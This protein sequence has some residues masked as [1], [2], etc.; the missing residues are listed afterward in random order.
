[1]SKMHRDA[2]NP[3]HC[4]LILAGGSG[5]RL[6]P[7]S[8]SDR[9]KQLLAITEART[10]FRASVERL[11]PILS[12]PQIFVVAGEKQLA[13]LREEAPFLP[14]ENFIS[15][16]YG[17]N[18]A[19]AT[20][21]GLAVISAR[22]PEATLSILTADHHIGEEEG[23]R[24]ALLSAV[25]LA[26]ATTPGSIV[27]LG[28]LPTYAATGFG[29][30]QLGEALGEVDGRTYHQARAFVEKPAAERAQTYYESGQFRWN[31]GMF[32]W[33]LA[34]AWAEFVRAQPETS[35]RFREWSRQLALKGMEADLGAAWDAAEALPL[36][37]AIMESAS[38]MLVLP[39]DIGWSDVGSWASVFDV[40]PR[41]AAGNYGKTLDSA[42][43]VQFADSRD[44][45]V[46][47]ETSRRVVA[48]GVSDLV[49]VETED[50]LLVC[51][52]EKAQD[53]RTIVKL[54]ETGKGVK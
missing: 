35:A 22:F 49:I 37:I 27:T 5:T 44:T 30:I 3:T 1:M 34:R 14:A 31:S 7:L 43:S 29:Y 2:G 28:I 54:N 4:A 9:P 36:D 52:R 42:G 48:L 45:L 32:V 12:P 19:P 15:E 53:V 10:L 6:W 18:T 25:A 11:L 41:D 23:F 21:L 46:L 33:T 20:L 38:D 13:A 17:K 16:P 24:S 39:V 40:L 8:R 50:A 47:S 51:H 26:N